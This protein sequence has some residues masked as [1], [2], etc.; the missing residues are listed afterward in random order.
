MN[1]ID[2]FKAM[3]EVEQLN[4]IANKAYALK[5]RLE[6]YGWKSSSHDLAIIQE[7][8]ENQLEMIAREE[9]GY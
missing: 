3:S 5:I 8:A 4:D 9:V 1:E 7:S 6:A 2:E